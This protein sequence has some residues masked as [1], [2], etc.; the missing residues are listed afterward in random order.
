MLVPLLLASLAAAPTTAAAEPQSRPAS[1]AGAAQADAPL[2]QARAELIRGL[3]ALADWANKNELFLQRENLW[4]AVIALEP[5]NAEARK[6]LRCA[7]DVTG[8]WKDPPARDLKDRKPA[9]LPEFARK[10]SALVSVWTAQVLAQLQREKADPARRAAACAEILRLDPDDEAVHA[11]QGELR[12]A[13][14]WVLGESAGAEARRSELQACIQEARKTP[15]KTEKLEPS[16]QDTALLPA[17]KIG[18]TCEGVRLLLQTSE[19][20]AQDML[21][22]EHA[23]RALLAAVCGK[24]LAPSPGFS[25]YVVVDAS[26]CDKLLGGV[27]EAAPADRQVWRNSTGFGVPRRAAVVAWDKDAKRRL[28]CFTR[29]LA[30]NCLYA[31]YG[32]DARQGWILDGLGVYLTQRL[33]GTRATWFRPDRADDNQA[34]RT[35][36]LLDTTDWMDEA[37]QLLQAG[38]APKL[39]ELLG[40]QLGS[41]TLED[42][43]YSN[44]FSAYLVE[45][46]GKALPEILARI[47]LGGSAPESI[48]NVTG[49]PLSEIEARFKRWLTE[50]H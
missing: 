48:A 50:Y 25:A 10:R 35:R 44:A 47:G 15:P 17:W 31:N 7:R 18:Y 26:D 9:A 6:A 40:K 42:M 43:L 14:G 2:A 49:R 34:L 4:R 22:A 39:A 45:G 19:A 16:A 29:H 33:T 37:Q 38:N 13:K 8:K 41:L 30:A 1:Q 24:P 11:L 32:I 23:L 5:E 36:L 12:G 28:D 21:G 27:S 46:Q 3:F 20:E